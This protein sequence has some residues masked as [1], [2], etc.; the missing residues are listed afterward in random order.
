M[1]S[2][3]LFL[4]LF[5]FTVP[6]CILTVNGAS[7]DI[8]KQKVAMT[9]L[10][11]VADNAYVN[12]HKNMRTMKYHSKQAK[13]N[14]KQMTKYI[15]T[16]VSK[17]LATFFAT[18]GG[19]GPTIKEQLRMQEKMLQGLNKIQ[20]A[21]QNHVDSFKKASSAAGAQFRTNRLLHAALPKEI[22]PAENIPKKA[23]LLVA[24]NAG[25]K[26]GKHFKASRPDPK[27]LHE[28]N[29]KLQNLDRSGASSK[30]INKVHRERLQKQKTQYLRQC[31]KSYRDSCK[32]LFTHRTIGMTIKGVK[33]QELLLPLLEA[34]KEIP[35]RN[36]PG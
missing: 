33:Q 8:T 31:A 6:Q 19:G 12:Y 10:K 15:S 2:A 35:R 17:G 34:V 11:D 36:S 16:H 22:K 5:F 21:K 29:T 18:L 20:L 25:E 23:L 24:Q 1:H 27:R 30:Q 26:A 32:D 4:L 7:Q 13:A 14:E 28:F 9:A 3:C